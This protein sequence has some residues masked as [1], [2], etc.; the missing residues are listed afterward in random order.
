MV[1]PDACNGCGKRYGH[2]PD[3]RSIDASNAKLIESLFYQNDSYAKEYR[4]VEQILGKV[5]GYP[6][7]RDDPKNFPN[8]SKDDDLVCVGDSTTSSLAMEAA[9]KI[10]ELSASLE[11][12]NKEKR[13]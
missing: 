13:K 4:N 6:A 8:H 3:C 9:N 7:F 12:A 1:L 5:L 2:S 10:K 11:Q